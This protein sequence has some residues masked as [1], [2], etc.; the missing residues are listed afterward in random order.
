VYSS[1]ITGSYSTARESVIEDF[2]DHYLKPMALS[3]VQNQNRFQ[4]TKTF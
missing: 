1:A 4:L 2:K 3:E